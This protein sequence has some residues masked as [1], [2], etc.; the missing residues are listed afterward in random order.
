MIEAMYRVGDPMPGKERRRET[1]RCIP[2][3]SILLIAL[4]VGACQSSTV[5]V[6]RPVPSSSTTVA[7]TPTTP[8]APAPIS[9]TTTMV[10]EV[11][12]SLYPFQSEAAIAEALHSKDARPNDFDWGLDYVKWIIG[13]DQAVAYDG[14][15]GTDQWGTFY[16]SSEDDTAYISMGI[17]GYN[18][19]DEPVIG[20]YQATTFF[21]AT[22]YE[23]AVELRAAGNG[24]MLEVTPPQMD[25]LG[26]PPGTTG[27]VLVQFES[28]SYEAA[29][30][31]GTTSIPMTDTP[32]T[33]GTLQ[34]SYRNP[35]GH[36]IGWHATVIDPS[37]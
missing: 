19:D 22:G 11:R 8:A 29:L 26:L 17:L 34:I 6:S 4:I 35:D 7:A 30:A 2:M 31:E 23:L 32:H 36:V 1:R 5:D 9:P 21:D 28:A 20:I 3:R 14:T 24:W 25:Q 15:D 13:W 27:D 33:W 18:P 10:E 12:R 16:R 37:H